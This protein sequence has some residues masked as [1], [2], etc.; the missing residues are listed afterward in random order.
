MKKTSSVSKDNINLS[1]PPFD[2]HFHCSLV[3]FKNLIILFWNIWVMYG[4]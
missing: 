4:L 3:N 2:F 1:K